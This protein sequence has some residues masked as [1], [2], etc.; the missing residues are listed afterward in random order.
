MFRKFNQ[1]FETP[2][3]TIDENEITNLIWSGAFKYLFQFYRSKASKAFVF[4]DHPKKHYV[5]RLGRRFSKF[6][7]AEI[8]E[9][10]VS[11][12]FLKVATPKFCEI[13]AVRLSK[14]K[15]KVW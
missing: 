3:N 8:S 6:P 5:K 7:T 10:S 4:F 13:S 14:S 1:K 9:I 15:Q 12:K 11:S 2:Y